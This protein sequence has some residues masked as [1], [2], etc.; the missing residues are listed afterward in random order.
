M[1][2]QTNTT[3]LELSP[4]VAI[5]DSEPTLMLLKHYHNKSELVGRPFITFTRGEDF[6]KY[7]E[8]VRRGQNEFPVIAL[9]DINM[10]GMDGFELI[11]RIK[12]DLLFHSIPK[13]I[14]LSSS[15]H[16]K[17]KNRAKELGA[18]NYIVKPDSAQDYIKIFD[19]LKD[20]NL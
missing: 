1:K 13:C 14:V 10:P 12:K 18:N 16:Y 4:I 20:A 8:G 15:D 5:D 6:L 11:E 7:L 19:S 17:D 3:P 9:I 2:N